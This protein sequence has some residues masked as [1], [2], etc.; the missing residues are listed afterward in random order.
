MSFCKNSAGTFSNP[1]GGVVCF[2]IAD[3][4]EAWLTVDEEELLCT[5]MV[6]ATTS[7]IVVAACTSSG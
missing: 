6:G 5:A 3:G 2:D 4:E 1:G 7:G